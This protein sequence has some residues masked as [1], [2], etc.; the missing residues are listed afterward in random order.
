MLGRHVLW[1]HPAEYSPQC[2]DLLESHSPIT[3]WVEVGAK[4]A[5]SVEKLTFS[6]DA[7]PRTSTSALA[8]NGDV[9]AGGIMDLFSAAFG[10]KQP[11]GGHNLNGAFG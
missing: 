6:A 10:Q 7:Q 8:P 11:V 4:G 3:L 9:Q 1:S 2:P 5:K